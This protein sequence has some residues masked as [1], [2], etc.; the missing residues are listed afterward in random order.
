MRIVGVVVAI[1]DFEKSGR[2]VFTVDDSSGA[3][4]ECQVVVASPTQEM[5]AQQRA[6]GDQ[7]KAGTNPAPAVMLYGSI[8]IGSVVDVKG[9][10]STFRDEKQINIEKITTLQST[11]QEMALWEKRTRFQAEVLAKPWVLRNREIRRCRKE[12]ERDDEEAER[13]RKQIRDRI[14]GWTDKR[15]VPEKPAEQP[16]QRNRQQPSKSTANLDL[17]QILQLEGRGKYD[18]LGL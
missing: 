17:E 8:D 12:A 11:S 15:S 9:G 5:D 7:S 2:R 4:I 3:C 13:K 1:D 6:A 14:K 18:A 10:I 16:P